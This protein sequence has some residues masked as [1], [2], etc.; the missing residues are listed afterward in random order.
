MRIA[1][2]NPPCSLR[3]KHRVDQ[4]S[5]TLP[6]G[7]A[8]LAAV[9]EQD[10]HTVKLIDAIAD[11]RANRTFENGLWTIGLSMSEIQNRLRQFEAELRQRL[12]P[13]VLCLPPIAEQDPQELRYGSLDTRRHKQ[14]P[15]QL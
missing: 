5:P 8:Y 12:Q 6:L 9:L 7:I 3:Q 14:V 11:G 2:I 10:G 15:L 13:P 1:L 4:F